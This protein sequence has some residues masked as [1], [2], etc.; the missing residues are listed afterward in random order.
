MNP[1]SRGLSPHARIA[2]A[3][4]SSSFDDTYET[5]V[6]APELLLATRPVA[7]AKTWDEKGDHVAGED[8]E[9]VPGSIGVAP[10][11]VYERTMSRWTA[12]IRKRLVRS[13]VWESKVIAAMQVR[14][15]LSQLTSRGS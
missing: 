6:S 5:G 4:S 1:G 8:V 7:L 9:A 15:A 2:S 12:A 13:I 11:E 14:S 3:E 10:D